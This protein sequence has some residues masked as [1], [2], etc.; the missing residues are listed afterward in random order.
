[1]LIF[2]GAGRYAYENIDRYIS[3]DNAPVCF[4]DVDQNKHYKHIKANTGEI[5]EILPINEA[6]ERY[7]ESEIVITTYMERYPIYESLIEFGVPPDRIRKPVDLP[8]KHDSPKWCPFI[9]NYFYMDG[10]GVRTCCERHSVILPSKGN[11]RDDLEQY[12]FY[13]SK[14]KN[15]LE[16]CQATSCSD[17]Y[18]LRDGVSSDEINITRVNLSSGIPGGDLCNFK[19]LYCTYGKHL[20]KCRYEENVYE[21]LSYLSEAS[22]VEDVLYASGEITV[23]PF[24]DEILDL[25]RKNRWKGSILTNASV[26]NEKLAELLSEG[27]VTLNCSLDAG[28]SKTFARIKGVDCFKDVVGNLTKYAS[29][30]GKITCKYIILDGINNNAEDIDG[31]LSISKDIDANVCISR[32]SRLFSAPMTESEYSTISQLVNKCR[33]MDIPYYL[34][35]SYMDNDIE[36]LERDGFI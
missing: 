29:T 1:M 34:L 32:D 13:T 3:E 26:Y 14:L 17:C 18:L 16:S 2:Y 20:G 28:T 8:K 21:V 9:G 10:Q 5:F 12:D 27:S 7:P 24:C 22:Q 6:I 31:F 35:L 25:W 4:S 15:K 23:S 36:R 30:G 19:C 11:I 33:A